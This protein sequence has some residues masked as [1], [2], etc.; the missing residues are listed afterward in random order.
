KKLGI[1]DKHGINLNIVPGSGSLTTAQLVAQ[2]KADLA[3]VDAATALSVAAKG[4][5]IAVV[6]PILQVNGYAI[7]AL[8]SSGIDS[9]AKLV[10]K[11]LSV[12]PG[13][14]PTVLLPA[15]LDSGGLTIGQLEQ[16]NMAAASQIGALL[17][18]KADAI[19][20]AGD[21]QGPQLMEQG[22]QVN[23]LFYYQ[24]G[25]PAVGESIVA[26]TDFMEK[27]PDLIRRF[28]D[29]SLQSWVETKKNPDAAAQAEAEQFPAEGTADK[30]LDQIK[31]DIE[32]LCAAPGAT[33]MGQVPDPVWQRTVSILKQFKLV[34]SD[35]DYTKFE[36]TKFLPSSPPSC[37]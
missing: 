26:N 36:T 13:I 30:E 23:Q 1:F 16:Q 24:N 22:Q 12:V 10:G 17:Q 2:G 19:V 5:D 15:V 20:A 34:P 31:V 35:F 7:I 25:V 4:G 27:N 29:A 32:L 11:R 6:A 3:Y 9:V 33:T 37:R 14:A 21:V 28:V 18:H 8:K